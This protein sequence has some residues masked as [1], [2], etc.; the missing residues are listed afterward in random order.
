MDFSA[1]DEGYAMY[2]VFTLSPYSS[3]KLSYLSS[4]SQAFTLCHSRLASI[5]DLFNLGL[6]PLACGTEVEG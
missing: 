4:L 5:I 1:L 6:K 2:K 3:R